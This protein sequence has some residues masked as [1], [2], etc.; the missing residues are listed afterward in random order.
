MAPELAPSAFA[1]GRCHRCGKLTSG[2]TSVSIARPGRYSHFTIC[3][4]CEGLLDGFLAGKGAPT[5]RAQ[6]VAAS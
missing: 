5:A 4:R 3:Y 2:E 6:E 1:R